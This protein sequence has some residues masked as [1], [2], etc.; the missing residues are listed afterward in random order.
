MK[1]LLF[2]LL[3]IT[4]QAQ[5]YKLKVYKTV[6]YARTGDSWSANDSIRCNFLAVIKLSKD[7]INLYEKTPE[8]FDVVKLENQIYL[9][10]STSIVSML[11]VDDSGLERQLILT[12]YRDYWY[13]K[14][15]RTL[16]NAQLAIRSDKFM[17]NFY[18]KKDD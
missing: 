17:I 12:V 18:L 15:D 4:I 13:D 3:P 8:S 1:Y 11:A 9:A 16:C 6:M 5:V 7:R 10:D 14:A 2:L